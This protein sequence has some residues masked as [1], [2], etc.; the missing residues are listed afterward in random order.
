MTTDN[1]DQ[2][3]FRAAV[4][5]AIIPATYAALKPASMFTTH[6]LAAQLLSIANSA[7]TPPKLAP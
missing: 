6:T 4:R 2:H 5:R 3:S 1:G 7:A